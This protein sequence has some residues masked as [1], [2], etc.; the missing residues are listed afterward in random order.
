MSITS[1]TRVKL[2]TVVRPLAGAP[3]RI[4]QSLNHDWFFKR[5][6]RETDD[7]MT[8][9]DEGAAVLA[10]PEWES[11]SVPH[12]VRLEPLNASGGRN[13][14]GVCWYARSLHIDPAWLG[15]TIYL[16]FEG[17][18]QVCEVWLNDKK[19]DTHF[20]GYTPFVLDITALVRPGDDNMLVLRLDNTDCSDVPPGK[21]LA[22]LDFVYFGGLYR[23][24]RLEA[25]HPLHVSDP[26][27]ANR[28]GGG[29]VFVTYP[30]VSNEVAEI[31]IRTDLR[32]TGPTTRRCNVRHDLI[33][34]D[35][36]TAATASSELTSDA[37]DF[38]TLQQTLRVSKPALWHP[39]HPHL[40]TL[41]TTVIEDGD[42]VD[43]VAAKIGIRRID[44]SPE[45]GLAINGKKF[46]SLGANRHQ[47][48]PYIGYAMSDAAQWRDARKLRDA[49]FTSIRSHY[50]QSPAFM[51]AC[52][53]LGLLTIVSNP[54]WQFVGGT[55]FRERAVQN[56]QLMVRRDRNRPSVVLWEAALNESD[57]K[58]VGAA[59]QQAVHEEFPGDQCFTA[60][61][62][63]RGF[64]WQGRTGW[65]VEYW[66]NDGTKPYW[67]REWG[68]RV[69]NW[70]DQQSANRVARGWG[71]GPM[72]TQTRSHLAQ[73]DELAVSHHGTSTGPHGRRLAGSCLWA[74]I[75]CQRGYHHQ[76]FFGGVMDAMRL[77]KFNYY[78]F[79]S[80]Q[81]PAREPVIFI[82]NFAT[83]LSPTTVTVFS[84]CEQVRLTQNGR[85][86]ATQSPDV[87]HRVAHPPFTFQVD[88][89]SGERSTM[90][91]AVGA[92]A[93]TVNGPP[94]LRA[95]GLIGNRVVVA[96]TVR[97]PGMPRRLALELDLAGQDLVADG[98][99]FLRVHARVCDAR[100][101][102]CPFADDWIQFDID[103]PAVVI[104]SSE[105]RANPIRA[106]GG[107]A[108]VLVRAMT[109]AGT[110][111]VR[112]STFGLQSAEVEFASISASR[113]RLTD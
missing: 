68:D 51:D 82:A 43:V 74:A 56:A 63:E 72:L 27:H 55:A 94:E 79:Q 103:G 19:L 67:I 20:G 35:E 34:A 5:C 6:D 113:V 71:E 3:A 52:D 41:R 69:D 1:D 100:G 65:D 33:D 59:L 92:D 64:S 12:T 109:R 102:V 47:D 105:I 31:Q 98:A 66:N 44:F 60:G 90:Y 110:I 112:A 10:A 58:E 76:P 17:C 7:A 84:N 21:P 45:N 2:P 111:R 30:H 39:D 29:G 62:H 104:D 13:F 80:Q 81:S 53:A 70:R 57:N 36:K 97:P 83:F 99:D 89:F 37:A 14:Q 4:V 18:M 42:V 91:M 87:G 15:R 86:I 101:T 61:D 9:L 26:I 23:N 40:Y 24:V 48:H 49:G 93:T 54:G 11:V 106:E 77:P 28:V 107:I 25:V 46:Y 108:S 85:E 88:P 96:Q 8:V 16:H 22:E 38:A 95:E 78:L 50:P 73:M 75:D 32:N